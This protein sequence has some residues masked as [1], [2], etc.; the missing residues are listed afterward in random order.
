[1]K[2]STSKLSHNPR[3][4]AYN[5]FYNF[6]K[7]KHR[8]KSNLNYHLSIYNRREVKFIKKIVFGTIRN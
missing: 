4:T 2:N 5:I 7:G 6:I 8:L 3:E 1:M